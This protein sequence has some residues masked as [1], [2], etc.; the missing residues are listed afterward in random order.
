MGDEKKLPVDGGQEWSIATWNRERVAL[1]CNYASTGWMMDFLKRVCDSR[2]KESKSVALK[3]ITW[4]IV[5]SAIA[6]GDA[7]K[8]EAV[9]R[10][11]KIA[12]LYSMS[13]DRVNA[14][15]G[16]L[17]KLYEPL[18][19]EDIMSFLLRQNA[20]PTRE[21][22]P[23]LSPTESVAIF[24]ALSG[25]GIINRAKAMPVIIG[26]DYSNIFGTYFTRENVLLLLSMFEKGGGV[27]CRQ[28][29]LNLRR[30]S[31]PGCL[32]PWDDYLKERGVFLLPCL[33]R[34]QDE[35]H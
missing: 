20:L 30:R 31:P 26:N 25:F 28:M 32:P 19:E 1:E 10:F 9:L 18:R 15:L 29:Y 3:Y 5:H 21:Q 16:V 7:K 6:E 13:S 8:L 34:E 14:I 12:C 27:C 2:T 4:P 22:Y 17:D 23:W 11:P 24:S 33:P 35:S